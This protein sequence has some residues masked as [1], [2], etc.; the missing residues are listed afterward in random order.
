MRRWMIAG[1]AILLMAGLASIR[2]DRVGFIPQD[3]PQQLTCGDLGTMIYV[4]PAKGYCYCGVPER[5]VGFGYFWV[6][7]SERE[8]CRE[9][10]L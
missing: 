3:W 10:F 6:T 5:F 7:L 4:E 2:V 1:L 8:L 9:P